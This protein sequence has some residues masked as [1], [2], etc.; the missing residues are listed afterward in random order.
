MSLAAALEERLRATAEELLLRRL[1]RCV[2]AQLLC[3][4]VTVVLLC[5][6]C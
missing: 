4:C 6:S 3:Y 1:R 2:A 5:L